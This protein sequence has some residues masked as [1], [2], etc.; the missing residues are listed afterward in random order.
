MDTNNMQSGTDLNLSNFK[1]DRFY[2]HTMVTPEFLQAIQNKIAEI[3]QAEKE[4]E[5]TL[6]AALEAAKK[7]FHENPKE[8]SSI[9]GLGETQVA[10]DA[11]ALSEFS[12]DYKKL[13]VFHAFQVRAT[14]QAILYADKYMYSLNELAFDDVNYAEALNL[15]GYAQAMHP[16]YNKDH[17]FAAAIRSFKTLSEKESDETRKNYFNMQI[18]FSER[19]LGLMARRRKDA[20]TAQGHFERALAAQMLLLDAMPQIKID[21]GET[22]HLIGATY[23]FA[24]NN[25]AAKIAYEEALKYEKE[26]VADTDAPHFMVGITGQ[27]LGLLYGKLGDFNSA[28]GLLLTT[29]QDQEAFYGTRKHADIAKTINFLAETYAGVGMLSEA[30]TAFIE[31]LEIKEGFYKEGDPVLV[32]TQKLLL[33]AFAKDF[34][35][36]WNDYHTLADNENKVALIKKILARMPGQEIFKLNDREKQAYGQ[37]LYKIGA[38]E[39]H[40]QSN[41]A[42]ALKTL[43]QAKEFLTAPAELAW[44]DNHIVFCYQKDVYKL[45][46]QIQQLHKTTNTEAAL[47]VDDTTVTLQNLRENRNTI[48]ASA[49]TLCSDIINNF[50]NELSGEKLDN[51][52]IIAFAFCILSFTQYES[53]RRQEGIISLSHAIDLYR[54]YK[55]ENDG[56]QFARAYNR[57]ANMFEE[58]NR[59]DEAKSVYEELALHWATHS[60]AQANP[61]KAKFNDSYSIYFEKSGDLNAA[62]T[63][64]KEA[65][66]IRKQREPTSNF[67]QRNAANI[68]TLEAKITASAAPVLA[69]VADVGLFRTQARSSQAAT[70]NVVTDEFYV[71]PRSG[72]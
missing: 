1:F 8:P 68:T 4:K 39:V 67:T 58:N 24:G 28:V 36:D 31:A 42:E 5:P 35:F 40:I 44:V 66:A 2:I 54:Q 20:E 33:Q 48:A 50:E 13:A 52:K 7:A 60:D 55:L 16:D 10:V 41:Q 15:C 34:T 27:S 63:Q 62:L 12:E 57:L 71:S 49:Q 45:N 9:V 65:Y 38:Y 25:A 51:V 18:A 26:F 59:M 32:I 29:A 14:A 70:A 6:F 19:Y 21:L 72:G 30:I 69:S 61:Q 17:Y 47:V 64:S 43:L 37:L 3:S 23:V 11:I 46:A 22:Q 56:D 53:D